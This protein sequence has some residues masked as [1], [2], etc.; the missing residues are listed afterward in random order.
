MYLIRTA[1]IDGLGTR[2]SNADDGLFPVGEFRHFCGR[3]RETCLLRPSR[4]DPVLEPPQSTRKIGRWTAATPLAK[5]M[6]ARDEAKWFLDANRAERCD[7]D[8]DAAAV[9]DDDDDDDAVD[10]RCCCC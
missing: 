8:F 9:D 7:G 1:G 4:K 10:D 6:S 2:V 3:R 5:S